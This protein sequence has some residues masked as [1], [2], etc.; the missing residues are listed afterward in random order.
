MEEQTIEIDASQFKGIKSV[1]FVATAANNFY[2]D[3]WQFT[4]Q[5][6][7]GIQELKA[8]SQQPKANSQIYDLS[9]RRV[10]DNQQHRGIVIK[11]GKKVWH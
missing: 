1:Y 8:N 11:N 9:G 6:A 3:A 7:T 4:E 5:G 2:V 10:S